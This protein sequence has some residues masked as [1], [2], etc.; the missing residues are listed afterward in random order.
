MSAPAVLPMAGTNRRAGKYLSFRLA[1]EEYAIEVLR[2]REIVKILH[3]TAVPETPAEVRGVI[4]LRGRVIPVID[5]R[6]KF[7]MPGAE[8]GPRT[9]IIVVE[10]KGTAQG[11]MG[12]IVDEVSEVLTLTDKDIQETPDFGRGVETPSLLGLA[13][14]REEVKIL[15]DIDEVLRA[16]DLSALRNALA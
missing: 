5:L 11:A 15:L 12:I 13:R 9:C 7:G 8:Y 10:L 2:V 3:I 6:L 16:A 1:D 4:N 14:I